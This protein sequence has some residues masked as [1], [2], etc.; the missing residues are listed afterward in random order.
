MVTYRYWGGNCYD[1][2]EKKENIEIVEKK[3]KTK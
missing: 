2:T 3:I 1:D